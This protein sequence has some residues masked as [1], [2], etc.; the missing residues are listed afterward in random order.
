MIGLPGKIVLLLI[1]WFESTCL[2]Y[3]QL[4]KALSTPHD[5]FI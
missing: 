2:K 4:W 1:L 5:L 3:Q